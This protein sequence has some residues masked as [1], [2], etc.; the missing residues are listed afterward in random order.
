MESIYDLN[1]YLS[2]I[3]FKADF[4]YVFLAQARY[5]DAFIEE[6]GLEVNLLMH[7]WG[8]EGIHLLQKDNFQAVG[9]AISK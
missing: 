9:Q 4:K 5:L 3:G 8:G 6:L 2:A 7:D 1:F